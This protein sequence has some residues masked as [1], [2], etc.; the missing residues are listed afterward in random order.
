M[1]AQ[2]SQK[3]NYNCFNVAFPVFIDEQFSKRQVKT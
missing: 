2:W 1:Y 3:K